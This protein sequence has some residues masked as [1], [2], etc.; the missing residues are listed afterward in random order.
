MSQKGVE[1]TDPNAIL[2]FIAYDGET[3]S[4]FD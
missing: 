1:T 3:T 2:I 4:E